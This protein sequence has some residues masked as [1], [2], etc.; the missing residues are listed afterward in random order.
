MLKKSVLDFFNHDL[1]G[2]PPS[3]PYKLPGFFS[4]AIAQSVQQLLYCGW[5]GKLHLYGSPYHFVSRRAPRGNPSPHYGDCLSRLF[6][7]S[8]L[9]PAPLEKLNSGAF[10]SNGPRALGRFIVLATRTGQRLW[11]SSFR[12]I[13]SSA[14]QSYKHRGL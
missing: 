3:N 10:R 11:I 8:L 6:F 14:P 2:L 4:L 12:R 13:W 5:Q 9:I 1:A 7:N